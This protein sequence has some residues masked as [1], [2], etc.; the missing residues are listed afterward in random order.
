M[1]KIPA[2]RGKTH[3]TRSWLK[4]AQGTVT[5]SMVE[6]Y[7]HIMIRD[8]S[9]RCSPSLSYMEIEIGYQVLYEI[10]CK[11]AQI[12]GYF[13]THLRPSKYIIRVQAAIYLHLLLY[14][15]G[16]CH[17]PSLNNINIRTFIMRSKALNRS[18]LTV[19]FIP[20][21]SKKS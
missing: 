17:F 14:F 15:Q 16:R 18:M 8:M 3:K 6:Y 5:Q 13:G 19:K 21:Q 2:A 9:L 12:S 1:K 20:Y 10:S 11:S 4:R 7:K